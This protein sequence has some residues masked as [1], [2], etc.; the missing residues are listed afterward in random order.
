MGAKGVNMRK[1]PNNPEHPN[2]SEY[3]SADWQEQPVL[4][5]QLLVASP[6][7]TDTGFARTVVLMLQHTE[8]GAAGVVLNRPAGQSIRQLWQQIGQEQKAVD[9]SF[10]FG[11][12]LPGPIVAL[13]RRADLG[14]YCLSSGLY[15]AAE[16]SC[17]QRLVVQ[18][19]D[20][21]RLFVGHAGWGQ[22]Q[23]EREL[24]YGVWMRL[25]ADAVDIFTEESDMWALAVREVGRSV[26]RAVIPSERIPADILTN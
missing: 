19:E 11:G 13:H 5:G 18:N 9:Q 3:S 15:V 12:P 10:H 25:P 4:A 17:L 21:F 24:K 6:A 7:V 1:I 26:Y 2:D 20:P 23:L 22:G 8:E 14:E 16:Q